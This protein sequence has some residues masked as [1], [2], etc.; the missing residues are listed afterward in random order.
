MPMLTCSQEEGPRRPVAV[1]MVSNRK[2]TF[3]RE[4]SMLVRLANGHRSTPH[5]AQLLAT[6]ETPGKLGV[7]GGKT[8]YFMFEKAEYNL[9]QFWK[10]HPV[11]ILD[12]GSLGR[13]VAKQCLGLI[14][15]L[16]IIH[17]FKPGPRGDDPGNR[18]HGLHGDIKPEN[19]LYFHNWKGYHDPRGL[20]QITDFGLSSFHGT[21]S[22]NNIPGAAN[23]YYY[24][25]PEATAL[26]R[27]S[28]SLDIWMMGCLF[29]ELL[30]WLVEGSR[31]LT[32][33]RHRR[34]DKGEALLW[35]SDYCFYQ[36]REEADPACTTISISEAVMKVGA[37]GAC[38]R[39]TQKQKHSLLL[40]IK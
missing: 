11:P 31:G 9:R 28:Q 33:F 4:R 22:A 3:Y 20:L 18:T 38:F 14:E 13:W 24:S 39:P 2:G 1:K 25:P 30:T 12:E 8:H 21:V 5:L 29:M 7:N 26:L 15:A 35:N 17:E 10:Q 19:I 36:V 37:P 40:I 6:F 32:E 27:V 16:H 23:A 34:K